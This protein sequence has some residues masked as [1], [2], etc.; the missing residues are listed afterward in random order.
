MLHQK[1][2]LSQ[3]DAPFAEKRKDID[4]GDLVEILDE[5]QEQPD[6]FNPGQT[7][8]I[9]KVK[10]KNGPRYMGLNQKSV[11]ILI[12]EFKS[13]D[14][15]KWIGKLAKVLL[16]PT[17]IGGKKVIVAFLVGESWEL[18]EYGEP[19]NPGAQA[20][21]SDDLPT[22]NLEDEQEVNEVEIAD[23]PF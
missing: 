11:N 21:T 2:E 12:D 16:N 6:R 1:T 8:T 22:V 9:I 19:V 5:C 20:T 18:D 4:D 13:N 10:T 15:K 3:L 14:D 17:T 23:V 7:Q